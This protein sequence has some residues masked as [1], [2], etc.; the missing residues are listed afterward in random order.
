MKNLLEQ[1][2][3]FELFDNIKKLSEPT[4]FITVLNNQQ[5]QEYIV[6]LNVDQMRLYYMNSDGVQLS[7]VGGEYSPV[8]V[9]LGNK[10][11]AQSVDLHDTGEFH[12]SFEIIDVNADGFTITSNPLKEDGTNLLDEWGEEIEGLTTENMEVLR[13]YLLPLFIQ[14]IKDSIL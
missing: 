5:T 10:K 6:K 2:R 3:L 14:Y 7:D 9:Q 1:T 12:E 8:T 4:M 11:N 13:G